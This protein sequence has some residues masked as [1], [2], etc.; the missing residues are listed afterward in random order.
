MWQWKCHMQHLTHLHCNILFLS[1]A[2]FD[3]SQ[4]QRLMHFHCNI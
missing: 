3:A 2:T 1:I 4:L